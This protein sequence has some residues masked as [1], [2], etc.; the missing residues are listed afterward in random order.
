MA[1]H[2]NKKKKKKKRKIK[3][4]TIEELLGEQRFY[5]SYIEQPK[6]KNLSIKEVLRQ[7]PFYKQPK[8]NQKE[9]EKNKV[10]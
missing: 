8:K 4:L 9:N 6:S 3:D 2:S 7:H 10:I 5:S 1:S